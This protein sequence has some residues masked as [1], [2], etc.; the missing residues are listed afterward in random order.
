MKF[1]DSTLIIEDNPGD[2]FLLRLQLEEIGWPMKRCETATNLSEAFEIIRR[3]NPEIIFLD[4]NLPDSNELET[5]FSIQA[6]ASDV[7]IIILS[8]LNDTALSL[9]AVQAGAQD[10]LTK[11]EYDKKILLKTVLYSIERKKTQLKLE[12]IN[13]RFTYASKATNDPL[14][15]MNMKTGEIV[16]NEKVGIFGYSK[17]V[18]K[19]QSWKLMNIH[20]DDK[21]KFTNNWSNFLIEGKENW[22]EQ[23]RF[24]CADGTYKYIYERAYLL[25]DRENKPYRMIGTMQDVTASV[26]QQKKKEIEKQQ[27][28]NAILKS[29]IQIQDNERNEISWELLENINQILIAANL[30]LNG[31]GFLKDIKDVPPVI[32]ESQELILSAVEGIKKLTHNIESTSLNFAGLVQTVENFINH[33]ALPNNCKII[34]THNIREEAISKPM[35]LT[36][37]RIIQD[38]LL[39]TINNAAAK[40]IKISSNWFNKRR[41]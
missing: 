37:F 23:F 17:T 31:T 21:E 15:D 24:R 40:N 11:G 26:Q 32:K 29:A 5:F 7:P 6:A 22:E 27:K 12:E 2:T 36:I 20:T 19:N 14:W 38:I 10:F 33:I 16:W 13:K 39:N 4:L 30:K 18:P 1:P 25:R 28:D 34:F 9:Q 3:I 8:G 41:K 35:A